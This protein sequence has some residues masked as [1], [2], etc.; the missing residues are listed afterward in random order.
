MQKVFASAQEAKRKDI[1]RA[2][3][4]LQA[5][6]HILTSG[7]CRLWERHAMKTVIKTSVILHNLVI[8]FERQI[9]VNSDYINNEMIIPQHP[10]VVI[11]RGEGQT[12]DTRLQMISAIQ[13]SEL[14]TQLQTIRMLGETSRMRCKND[15]TNMS[16]IRRR[17]ICP[18]QISL[19]PWGCST[20]RLARLDIMEYLY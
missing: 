16:K 15:A 17:P 8:D 11:S 6:F 20:L 1:K 19:Q 9:G 4:M 5:R 14:H 3:G 12:F 10:V 18:M 7:A 2:F 13:N